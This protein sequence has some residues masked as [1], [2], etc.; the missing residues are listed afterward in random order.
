MDREAWWATV[1]GAA[2]SDTTEHSA[3]Q[4]SVHRTM[5][6]AV[7]TG[8]VFQLITSR[9]PLDHKNMGTVG[10]MVVLLPSHLTPSSQGTPTWG[11][12]ANVSPVMEGLTGPQDDVRCCFHPVMVQGPLWIRFLPGWLTHKST[13][14]IFFQGFF[15]HTMWPAGS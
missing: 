1:Q 13:H 8:L 12:R 11:S 3:N 4:V 14:L 7:S 2:A 6:V 5:C 9:A 10:V 15:G